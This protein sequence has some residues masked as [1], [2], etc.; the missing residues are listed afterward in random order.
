MHVTIRDVSKA[1]AQPIMDEL[2]AKRF[3]FNPSAHYDTHVCLLPFEGGPNAF[4]ML[5]NE[6]DFKAN[7][8]SSI[9]QHINSCSAKDLPVG[10]CIQVG[11]T[12]V[13]KVSADC[14]FVVRFSRIAF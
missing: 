4:E 6:P 13:F 2:A 12:T 3:G 1:R 7:K 10:D 8:I 11:T 14:H 5:K 9:Q